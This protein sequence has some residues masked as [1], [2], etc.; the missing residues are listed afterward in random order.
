MRV[1]GEMHEMFGDD[2]GSG[3]RMRV[4]GEV[5]EMLDVRKSRTGSFTLSSCLLGIAAVFLCCLMA[6]CGQT[7]QGAANSGIIELSIWENYNNEEHKVF[8]EL[9]QKFE[10]QSLERAG[11][12]IKLSIGRVP[13]DGLLPRLKTSCQTR[14]TPD[15]CR[16]D[17]AHVVS[18]AYGKSVV[19]LD[20]LENFGAGSID[21][22]REQF[23]EAA[24]D[25]NI[26][27]I[28]QDDG[29]VA[30]HL[31]GLPDQTTCVALYW[32]RALFAASASALEAAGLSPDRSP[33]TWE[34]FVAYGKVLTIPDSSQYAFGMDNSLWWT[35]PFFNSFGAKFLTRLPDGDLTCTLNG[36]KGVEALSFKVDLYLKKHKIKGVETGIE[37]GAWQSGAINASQG[38][39]NQ[40]YA[41]ILSGPWHLKTF[42]DSGL[43]FRVGLIPEG[44]AGTSSNVGG[45][46]FVVFKSCAE[47]GKAEAAY[48][49]LK[50]ITS[51]EFQRSWCERLQQIPVS[52]AV[53][54]SVDF[55][56]LPELEVFMKQMLSAKA[57]PRIPMY[58]KLEEIINPEMELALKGIKTPQQCLDDSVKR[59]EEEILTLVNQR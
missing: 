36:E 38:F 2:L 12:K 15:I 23:V 17:C 52:K 40:K 46:N 37:A 43:D 45:T 25:S 44:R 33:E 55:S 32:N 6:G 30:R 29:K 8:I 7:E 34:E 35:F 3:E 18:L 31:Y 22:L 54:E 5:N 16:V 42:K 27:E 53:Y 47:A 10:E 51:D 13:F 58:D 21:Q 14:T 11:R 26:I 50:Y 39:I 59:I 49:V 48:E 24:F 19:P 56:D 9:M 20:T 4:N 41:M 57:R 1:N 28:V